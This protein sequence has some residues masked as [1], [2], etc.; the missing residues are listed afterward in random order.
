MIGR[1]F[2]TE[3]MNI[4][5]FVARSR[6]QKAAAGTC[7][8]R[9]SVCLYAYYPGSDGGARL[10][11]RW[12]ALASAQQVQGEPPLRYATYVFHRIID[13]L[14]SSMMADNNTDKN[15]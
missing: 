15:K 10:V 2:A 3:I 7:I 1:V 4:Y 6:A 9:S 5:E 14:A 12:L 11:H 8:D 13:D